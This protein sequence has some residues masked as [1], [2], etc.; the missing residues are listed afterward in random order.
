MNSEPDNN[1]RPRVWRALIGPVVS[2]SLLALIAFR[3]ELNATGD[4]LRQ[5]SVST[6]LVA[7]LLLAGAI[8]MNSLRWRLAAQS[9]G[10][11][12]TLGLA[13]R[14]STCG[15]FFNL[16]LFGPAGGDIAKSATYSRWYGF[17]LQQLLAASLVDRGFSVG[18]ST[19]F[20]IVT[21]MALVVF[22]RVEHI[23]LPDAFVSVDWLLPAL[24]LLGL[25]VVG[26]VAW[27]R[28]GAF[29]RG[30]ARTFRDTLRVVLNSPSIMMR[31]CLNGFLQQ[32]LTSCVFAACLIAVSSP[33]LPWLAM[34]WTFPLISAIAVLPFTFGGAGAR[35]GLALLLLIPFGVQPEAIVAAGLLT[36]ATYLCWAAIGATTVT[37]EWR[38]YR[39]LKVTETP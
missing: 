1:D 4:A 19:L 31:G 7:M 29:L 6:W 17:S 35:E 22:G 5:A 32:L 37:L 20:L 16:L 25:T 38:R 18:G 13:T 28:R 3:L 12:V 2:L 21:L 36:L 24:L 10:L 33:D 15:T 30:L 23:T 9:A 39:A 14:V 8:F 27:R 11:D 34:A 26:V